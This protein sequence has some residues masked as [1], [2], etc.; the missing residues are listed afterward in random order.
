MEKKP[1]WITLAP[2]I[3]EL[4]LNAAEAIFQKWQAGGVATQADFDEIRAKATQ[5]AA[6]RTRAR[7]IANGIEPTSAE[8]LKILALVG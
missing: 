8:G 1:M 4:G 2:L 5:T 6:D 3:A 7:L